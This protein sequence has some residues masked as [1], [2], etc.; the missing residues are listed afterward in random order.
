MSSDDFAR[1]SFYAA[2]IAAMSNV[3]LAGLTAMYVLLTRQIVRQIRAAR[4]PSVFFDLDFPESEVRVVVG[5]SGESPALNIRFSITEDLP[6]RSPR[7]TD[8]LRSIEMIRS[9]ISFLAPRRTLKLLGGFIDGMLLEETKRSLR[10][11]SR[12]RTRLRIHSLASTRS[13]FN[14][15]FR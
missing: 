5:N 14:S 2:L 3:L 11:R 6:W 10:L 13:T 9:G 1:F 4:E 12:S 8:G 7:M 15:T